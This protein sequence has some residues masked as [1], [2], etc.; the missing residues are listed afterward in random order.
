MARES[1]AGNRGGQVVLSRSP[2]APL[3]PDTGVKVSSR[4][5]GHRGGGAGALLA[6]PLEEVA[7]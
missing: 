3:G 5:L 2:A 6:A 4:R 1:V 7:R